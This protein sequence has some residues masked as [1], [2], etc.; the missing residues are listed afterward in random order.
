MEGECKLCKRRKR[1]ASCPILD[2]KEG[3]KNE[4]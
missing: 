1:L 4:R 2:E 3:E